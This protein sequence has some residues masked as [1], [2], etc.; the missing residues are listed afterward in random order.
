MG[1]WGVLLLLANVAAE[2]GDTTDTEDSSGLVTLEAGLS[3]TRGE[4]CWAC[5]AGTGTDLGARG[6]ACCCP[7][8]AA[9]LLELRGECLGVPG[10][11]DFFKEIVGGAVRTR[12]STSS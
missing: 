1:A 5:P 12:V 11:P 8:E 9:V 10:E 7:E 2:A 6:V 4:A 3:P